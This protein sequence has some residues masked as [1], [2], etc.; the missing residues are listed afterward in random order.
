MNI[1]SF[2]PQ[3]INDKFQ[4]MNSLEVGTL[5]AVYQV[6]FIIASIWSGIQMNSIGRRKT[7][8]IA[9]WLMGVATAIF[10]AASYCRSGYSFYFISLIA[11]MVSGFGDGMMAVAVPAII[12]IEFTDDTE[13]YLGLCNTSLGVGLMLGPV[14]GV[15]VYSV[16]SYANTFYFFSALILLVGNVSVSLV[17]KRLDEK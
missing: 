14:I 15:F 1:V 5:M 11:R 17:P 4:K 13:F 3:Y 9:I 7:V 2:L 6:T 8:V 10:G 16:L 12:V